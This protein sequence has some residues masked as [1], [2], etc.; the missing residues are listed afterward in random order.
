MKGE[1]AIVHG[2]DARAAT[3]L[4]VLASALR[5]GSRI[6]PLLERWLTLVRGHAIAVHL[7]VAVAITGIIDGLVF[8]LQTARPGLL[9]LL[10]IELALALIGLSIPILLTMAALRNQ[11]RAV[12][13]LVAACP[14]PATPVMLRLVNEELRE[15]EDSLADLKGQGSALETSRASEWVRRRCFEVTHGRYIGVDEAA[16]SVFMARYKDFLAA[17]SDYLLRTG[18]KDCVRVNVSDP[19]QLD[20]DMRSNP[21]LAREYV[22]WHINHDVTLLHLPL[23]RALELARQH[24]L[25]TGANVG[26]WLGDMALRWDHGELSVRLRA[27]LVGEPLYRQCYSYLER[28]LAEAKTLS[29]PI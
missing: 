24:R 5:K 23:D 10:A 2:D 13:G 8:G 27:G 9:G 7:V 25:G 21:S 17:Q 26:L 11:F 22:E 18:R 15:L 28:V 1:S 29:T 20:E 3:A 6:D 12:F 14:A 4:P 16:P 19:A